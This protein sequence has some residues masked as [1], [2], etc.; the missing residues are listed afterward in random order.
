MQFLVVV[1]TVLSLAAL[2]AAGRSQVTSA[3]KP[4]EP[5][6]SNFI[7][8]R[9]CVSGSML[10][11]AGNRRTYRL[12]GSRSLLSLLAKEHQGHVEEVTGELKSERRMGGRKTKQVGK[13][14]SVYVGAAEDRNTGSE[15]PIPELE[16][17]SF[18]HLTGVCG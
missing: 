16:V 14:T 12:K 3:P 9:G 7:V 15:D 8:V 18:E 10:E 1:S 2:A 5:A 6:N 11:D 13:K 4:K 17:K